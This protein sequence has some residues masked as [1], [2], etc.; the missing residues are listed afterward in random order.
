M[1]TNIFIDYFVILYWHRKLST[2][3]AIQLV[4]SWIQT[5]RMLVFTY[6]SVTS[7]KGFTIEENYDKAL[8]E[9]AN[10]ILIVFFY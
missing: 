9:A 1:A 7:C 4:Y 5:G 6:F 3:Q 8:L 10:C 2:A